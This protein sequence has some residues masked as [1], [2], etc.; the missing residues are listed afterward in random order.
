AYDDLDRA[1]QV[2]QYLA[3]G[4]GGNRVTQTVYNADDTVQR[5]DKAVGTSIA[6]SYV[7]Y[8]YTPNG[9]LNSSQDAKGNLTVYAYDGFDRRTRIYYP[10]PSTPGSA[11]TNDYEEYA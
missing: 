5:I 7:Q 8:T 6:Q 1:N 10:Q 2:T 9:N 11:N 3:A 4:D